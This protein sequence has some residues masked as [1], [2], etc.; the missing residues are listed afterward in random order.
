M[1][2]AVRRYSVP[3]VTKAHVRR[4]AR[5]GCTR[6]QRHA[7]LSIVT[8]RIVVANRR[9]PNSAA[10]T[11]VACSIASR[12]Q[13]RDDRGGAVGG[14]GQAHGRAV[15][16]GLT[17][18]RR[19]NTTGAWD[20]V[21]AKTLIMRLRGHISTICTGRTRSSRAWK[22]AVVAPTV[23]G[24]QA[25]LL[26]VS[27]T[28]ADQPE[29]HGLGTSVATLG[30][31]HTRIARRIV[32]VPQRVVLHSCFR[33]PFTFRPGTR[34]LIVG[35]ARRPKRGARF[36]PKTLRFEA[37][38]LKAIRIGVAT[39][40]TRKPKASD[41][42]SIVTNG[43]FEALAGGVAFLGAVVPSSANGHTS[44]I[45]HAWFSGGAAGLCATTVVTAVHARV[46]GLIG[47]WLT[48]LQITHAWNTRV[49]VAVADGITGLKGRAVVVVHAALIRVEGAA[50]TKN[51]HA[52]S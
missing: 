8:V 7:L 52:G 45:A 13:G 24:T 26:T 47:G 6:G 51:A 18:H 41:A 3:P 30:K 35:G 15:T 46:V 48:T 17:R 38:Y 32:L 39:D 29:I 27:S 37:A 9:R 22:D 36:R 20:V 40:T 42:K 16:G 19:G 2:Y 31:C 34:A 10:G 11:T 5:L 4:S 44:R 21:V 43:G 12:R 33:A 50:A 28:L 14:I 23:T 49:P 1:Q 25:R